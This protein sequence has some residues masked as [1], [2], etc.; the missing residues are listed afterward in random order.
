MAELTQG[1]LDARERVLAAYK[2][3]TEARARLDQIE[4]E[5]SLAVNELVKAQSE[6]REAEDQLADALFVVATGKAPARRKYGEL[7]N[8]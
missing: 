1:E 2:R 6:A 5:R 8:G 3:R 4:A 7:G